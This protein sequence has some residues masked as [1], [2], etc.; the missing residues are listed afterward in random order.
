MDYDFF[1]YLSR[2]KYIKRWSLMRSTNE[3]NIMEHSLQVTEIAHA[4]S[5][6]KNEMFGGN[7]D[8]YKV[9]CLAVYHETSEVITGDLPTPIKYFNAQINS[10]YK[11]LEDLAAE[12]L[13][14]KLPEE[15]KPLYREFI[16]ADK[17][18]EEYKIMK[19]ADRISAY[20]KCVEEVKSGNK[21]FVKAKESIGKDI[22]SINDE[23]VKYFIKN[24][25][26]SFEKT[27]DELDQ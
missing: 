19:A 18:T 22:K 21:E 9:M 20:I 24:I 13:I 5:L 23:A 15:L 2:M 10:A 11:D 7:V 26:P 12:K 27:L 17:N 6:I 1:A 4:I 25:L 8:A 14:E 3:E 16:L